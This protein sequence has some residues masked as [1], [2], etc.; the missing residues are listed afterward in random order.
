MLSSRFSSLRKR[1]KNSSVSLNREIHLRNFLRCDYRLS[2]K[3]RNDRY[4]TENKQTGAE[5]MLLFR[6]RSNPKKEPLDMTNMLKTNG[7]N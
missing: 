6:Q 4:F 7:K 2:F 1:R 3:I 5:K